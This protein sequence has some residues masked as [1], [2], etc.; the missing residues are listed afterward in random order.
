MVAESAS[1]LPGDG[2][3]GGEKEEAEEVKNGPPEK[4]TWDAPLVIL[5]FKFFYA[6]KN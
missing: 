6:I 5:M 2:E 1:Q 3:E 4:V